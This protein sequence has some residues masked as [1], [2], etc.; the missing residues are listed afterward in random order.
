MSHRESKSLDDTIPIEK[1]ANV[2]GSTE[3][4]TSISNS[5]LS[6]SIKSKSGNSLVKIMHE[7]NNLTDSESESGKDKE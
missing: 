4:N 5:D 6:D 7:I 1:D 2:S 3:S